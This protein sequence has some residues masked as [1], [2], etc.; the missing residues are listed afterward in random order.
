M[1]T[2]EELLKQQQ[3]MSGGITSAAGN[4]SGTVNGSVGGVGQGSGG[5]GNVS[6]PTTGNALDVHAVESEKRINELFDAQKDAQ[7]KQLESAYNQ[8]LADAEEAKGKIS[9]QYQ[10]AA[11]DLAVQYERNKRNLNQQIA[12]NGL[13]TGTGSQAALAQNSAYQRDF[14]NLRT[15]EAEALTAADTGINR[16]KQQYQTDI[17][18]AIADNDY[19]RAA[20][21]LDEYNTQYTREMQMAEMLAQYG[22]FSGY[23]KILGASAAAQ[24]QRAWA[25]ENP[26]MAYSLGL[27]SNAEYMSAKAGLPIGMATAMGGSSGG[28]GATDLTGFGAGV[29]LDYYVGNPK[30][31]ELEP[32]VELAR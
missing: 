7:L 28:G 17:G 24:M 20:A 30:Y 4:T 2:V 29:P 3:N 14:G 9:P 27:I 19:K 8:N 25:A 21:L 23:T 11:N 6:K 12:A 22:D 16:L 18:V 5:G 15:S 1:A 31:S 32:Y 26:E 13:N 10:A